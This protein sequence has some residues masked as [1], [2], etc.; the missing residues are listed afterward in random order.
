MGPS[1]FPLCQSN[2]ATQTDMTSKQPTK[3]EPAS[4]TQNNNDKQ[5]ENQTSKLNLK[6]SF[7]GQG[8]NVKV[9]VE[10]L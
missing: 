1:F 6:G 4:A 7:N 8:A 9:V 2:Q 10:Q 5:A 3:A